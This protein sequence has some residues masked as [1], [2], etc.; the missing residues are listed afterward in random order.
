MVRLTRAT[1]PRRAALAAAV[2]LALAVT[3]GGCA[4]PI[5]TLEAACTAER[6]VPKTLPSFLLVSDTQYSVP[7]T[8]YDIRYGFGDAIAEL[9]PALTTRFIQSLYRHSEATV[10]LPGAL[11]GILD[12]EGPKGRKFGLFGGDLAEFACK[13][14]AEEMLRVF[15]EHP[16]T[17]FIFTIGNHDALFHGSYDSDAIGED[18]KGPWDTYSF[19]LWG[20]VCAVHG[21]RLTKTEYIRLLLHYYERA[22]GFDFHEALGVD[23]SQG[24]KTANQDKYPLGVALLGRAQSK[25]IA[26]L[27]LDF[28]FALGPADDPR[29]H[30][31]THLYQRWSYSPPAAKEPPWSASPFSV[32]V[33]DT[34]DYAQQRGLCDDRSFFVQIGMSGAVSLAQIEWLERLPRS[35]AP[36]L[37][38]SHYLPFESVGGMDACDVTHGMKCQA[39]RFAQAVGPAT[40]VYAHVHKEFELERLTRG[41]APAVSTSDLVRL[42]SLIDNKSYVIFDGNGFRSERALKD[43]TGA[44]PEIAA[45]GTKNTKDDARKNETDPFELVS[46]VPFT[47]ASDICSQRFREYVELTRNVECFLAR[48]HRPFAGREARCV[49]LKEANEKRSGEKA[50]LCESQSSAWIAHRPAEWATLTLPGHECA[51]IG[52]TPPFPCILRSLAKRALDDT[53]LSS[54]D[55]AR[56]SIELLDVVKTKRAGTPTRSLVGDIGFGARN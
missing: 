56:L 40:F 22:F 13:H 16:N 43:R 29:S 11:S 35:T 48:E 1:Q 7:F 45:C 2:T 42:P 28:S 14:E 54:V 38:L 18:G 33:L 25:K 6:P 50:A 17:P 12:A 19:R 21:G 32:T 44:A 47:F 30:R 34:T 27:T 8:S 41:T 15:G 53:N 36:H 24:E 23:R 31:L 3:A 4:K 55:R 20:G 26:G 51:G 37:V 10:A 52:K 9:R 39:D 5:Y 46:E 49:S